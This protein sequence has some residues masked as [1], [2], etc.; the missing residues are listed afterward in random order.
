MILNRDHGGFGAQR[1]VFA[2]DQDAIGELERAVDGKQD[3]VGRAELD[4]GVLDKDAAVL[5]EVFFLEVFAG[6]GMGIAVGIGIGIGIGAAELDGNP[7]GSGL[8]KEPG[9]PAND[10]WFESVSGCLVRHGES[11]TPEVEQTRLCVFASLE[12]VTR[13]LFCFIGIE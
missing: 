13:D 11:S 4:D 10:I 2:F 5:V 7:H 6:L 9:Q 3:F 1:A 8:G 12:E